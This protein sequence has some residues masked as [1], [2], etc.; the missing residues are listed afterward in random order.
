MNDRL[1]RLTLMR[2][3]EPG[4][5]ALGALVALRGPQAAVTLVREGGADADFTRWFADTHGRPAGGSGPCGGDSDPRGGGSGAPDVGSGAGDGRGAAWDGRLAARFDR[6]VASWAARLRTADP[7]RDLAEGERIGA[8]LVI[9]GDAEWPSQLDDLGGSRPH[10]LWLRGDADLRFS[11]LRSVAVV[12]SRA[13][14]PYGA[15]VAAELG[16]GLSERGWGVVS[17]GAYGI[18]GAA[19]RGA[20]ACEA[21]TVVVLACGADVAYPSAHQQLFAAV[22]EQGVL[23]SECP[24]GAHPTRPRFLIRNRLI[25]ALSRS[26]VVVEA[27]VRSGALNTAGHAIA[28]NRHLAAVPGP[29]TSEASA[30]CH[31]LIRQGR[32]VCVT[33]AEEVI[34]LAGT[35]GADLAP[36]ARGPVL[37]RDRLDPETRKVVEAMPTRIGVGP[38]TIAVAAGVD[39]ETV[40]SCLGGLAAAGYVERVSRGWRLRSDRPSG[41]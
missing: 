17:G 29:V 22:R 28:L 37:P 18:D 2:L 19:H 6:T 21:P 7:E 13:A 9:P 33:G 25:A 41:G 24:M 8:R 32:A 3:A 10:G 36:E 15:H 30:G 4:D 39:L 14:T 5:T 23:V 26:T 27:A 35:M 1:A 20:L 31:R 38:A 12:G 40:L 11:C 16:A 34:E